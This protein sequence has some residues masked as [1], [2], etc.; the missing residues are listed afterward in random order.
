MRL[1]VEAV[2]SRSLILP[3]VAALALAGCAENAVRLDVAG[4]VAARSAETARGVSRYFDEVEA[5]RRETAAAVVASDPSCLPYTSLSVQVPR[6]DNPGDPNAPLCVTGGR[7]LAGYDALALDL[8]PTPEAI[9]RPRA[10][11]VTAVVDYG[12]ALAEIVGNPKA[13]VRERMAEF[14]DKV[15]RV[16]RIIGLEGAVAGPIGQLAAFANALA[17]EAGQVKQVR[18]LVASE[19]GKVDAALVAIDE[20]IRVRLS[21]E[22]AGLDTLYADA[23]RRG[24]R[25]DRAKMVFED[26]QRLARMTFEADVAAQRA[27]MRVAAVLDAIAETKAAQAELRNILLESKKWPRARREQAARINLERLTRALGHLAALGRAFA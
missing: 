25:R 27:P 13:D 9:L 2:M 20:Q 24:Y 17:R 4:N 6:L 14:A 5:Q 1:C 16:G 8:G 18:T 15:E 3:A 26:R 22:S 23:L 11:L 21:G 19:G 7:P 10:L 12:V